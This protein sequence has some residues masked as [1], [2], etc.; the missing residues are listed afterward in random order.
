MR[1][2]PQVFQIGT[3]WGLD[4]HTKLYFLEGERK[5][6][7][8]TGVDT[9]PEQDIAP[10][11]SYYGYRLGDID[12]ILNTHG[13]YDHVD[14]NPGMP[15]AEVAIHE[16]DTFLLED[17]EGAFDASRR[18][19]L[20]LRSQSVI[21]S[22]RA[23]YVAGFKKLKVDRQLKDGDVVDLGKGI[24]L[25]VVHL[26]GHTKGSVGYLWEKEGMLF[27]GDSVADQDVLAGLPADQR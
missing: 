1:I 22:E 15:Q 21:E 11:L 12:L 2:N 16:E 6:I 23:R 7:I 9:S 18:L 27:M 13:H 20:R 26:P 4:N 8:D 3:S 19:D 24:Q 14:G 10:Y 5:A 17:P 25:R